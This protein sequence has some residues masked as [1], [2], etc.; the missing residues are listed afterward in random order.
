[1]TF[2]WENP[3]TEPAEMSFSEKA[4]RLAARP[5]RWARVFEAPESDVRAA[6]NITSQ[7]NAGQRRGFPRGQFEAVTR[8]KGGLAITYA[9]RRP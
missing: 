3:E 1:M 9:R 5:G 6:W 2:R 8:R 4:A 7:I